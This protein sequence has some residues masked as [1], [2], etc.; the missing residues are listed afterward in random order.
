MN[1]N[2]PDNH[3]LAD[4]DW[5]ILSEQDT[6]IIEDHLSELFTDL[7]RSQYLLE[8]KIKAL[9]IKVNQLTEKI[10]SLQGR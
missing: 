3:E 7:F 4:K 8:E 10:D 6:W 5:E 9:E 2:Y 1:N